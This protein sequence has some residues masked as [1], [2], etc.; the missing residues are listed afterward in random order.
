MLLLVSVL[1]LIEH[2]GFSFV[3]VCHTITD[4]FRHGLPARAVTKTMDAMAQ[5][6]ISPALDASI[7]S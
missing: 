6:L 5:L 4:R 7:F 1:A 3:Q 2:T